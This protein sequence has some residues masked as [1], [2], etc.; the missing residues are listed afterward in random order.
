MAKKSEKKIKFAVGSH[1]SPL[2]AVWV[3]SASGSD[4][5]VGARHVMQSIK[6]SLHRSGRW[7]LAF[8]S[9]SNRVSP[10]TG[11]RQHTQL[12]RPSEF[13]PGWTFGTAIFVPG[14]GNRRLYLSPPNPWPDHIIRWYRRPEGDHKRVFAIYHASS[15]E[16]N[17]QREVRADSE[18]VFSTQLT[19][20]EVLYVMTWEDGMDRNERE[21]V[22]SLLENEAPR[23][24]VVGKQSEVFLNLFHYSTSDGIYRITD[25]QMGPDYVTWKGSP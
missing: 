13:L 2:S 14:A 15:P 16:L 12:Q 6:L 10:K 1:D 21:Y 19:N 25:L 7:N 18:E 20:G 11:K 8:T 3:V 4:V 5:Y 22:R 17:F 9:E 24:D 23:I